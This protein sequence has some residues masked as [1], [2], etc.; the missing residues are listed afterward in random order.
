VGEHDRVAG[1]ITRSMRRNV[2]AW[3]PSW[4]FVPAGDD[5]QNEIVIEAALSALS[6]EKGGRS[7]TD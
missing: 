1:K 4:T 6:R 5:D 2:R 3:S 7:R